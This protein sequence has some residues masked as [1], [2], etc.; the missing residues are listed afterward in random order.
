M[1]RLW[2]RHWLN[3][4][5]GASP[6]S[7][8]RTD[9]PTPQRSRL[10]PELLESRWVPSAVRNLNDACTGSLRQAILDAPSGGTVIFRPGLSGTITLT[11]GE[12]LIS[13]DLTTDG[14]GASVITIS[15]NQA[16]RVFNIAATYTVNIS[17]LTI[18]DGE[19]MRATAKGGGILN[20]GTLTVTNSTLS[21]NSADGGRESME[22]RRSL[23]PQ[24]GPIC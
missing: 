20:A 4:M 5:P 12:L 3:R 11:T 21:G 19:V 14:P 23:P 22:S 13:K 9:R 10:V 16:S 15:G 24:S 1:S 2:L 6:R 18:T 7:Q 8:R 17:G